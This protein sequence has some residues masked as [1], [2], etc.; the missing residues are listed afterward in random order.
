[1][2]VEDL[3]CDV[4]QLENS[5]IADRIVDVQPLFAANDDV[6]IPQYSQLL[7]QRALFDIQR[8]AQIIDAS[9]PAPKSINYGNPQRMCQR[10]EEFG[11]KPPQIRHGLIII[12]EYCNVL[13]NGS[14]PEIYNLQFSVTARCDK[15]RRLS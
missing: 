9:F 10:F 5:R 8:F 12:Y 1:M 3:F 6:S 15:P 7:R 4:E 14:N 2:V 13:N 11:F